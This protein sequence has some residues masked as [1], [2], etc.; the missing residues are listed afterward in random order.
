MWTLN[1]YTGYDRHWV[2]RSP[3]ACYPSVH[4]CPAHEELLQPC[5]L[6]LCT[7]SDTGSMLWQSMLY[8]Q[9]E[10]FTSLA[11]PVTSNAVFILC[12]RE[13]QAYLLMASNFPYWQFV[14]VSGMFS[15]HAG[16]WSLH[17]LQ[18]NKIYHCSHLKYS[19]F[20]P[21]L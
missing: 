9:T 20:V 7:T 4:K 3:E 14:F 12:W 10:V 11:Q 17:I 1:T 18:E 19:L 15:W 21:C 2:E 5:D 6:H 16:F 13:K 8:F